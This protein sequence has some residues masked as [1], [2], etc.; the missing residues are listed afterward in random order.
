MKKI[1]GLMLLIASVHADATLYH[2]TYQGSEL[3]L[4]RKPDYELIPEAPIADKTRPALR[5]Y[6]TGNGK[7]MPVAL[8]FFTSWMALGGFKRMARAIFLP[9]CP[10]R[11]VA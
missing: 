2:Y 3:K 8:R 7:M 9:N 6:T 5:K 11:P 1:F 10:N 4:V